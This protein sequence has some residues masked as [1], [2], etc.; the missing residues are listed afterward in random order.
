M[1][2]PRE[3]AVHPLQAEVDPLLMQGGQPPDH[4]I[5]RDL[6]AFGG[7]VHACG[8][9]GAT[10]GADT[11]CAGLT[12]GCADFDTVSSAGDLVRRRQ[13]RASVGRRSWRCTTMS[14]M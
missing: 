11:I 5:E 10:S 7:G 8:A 3:Q 1:A 12:T 6:G 13:S 9:A 2:E 14:T 4:R